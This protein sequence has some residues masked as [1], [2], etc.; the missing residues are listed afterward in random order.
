[1]NTPVYDVD[2]SQWID[3]KGVNRCLQNRQGRHPERKGSGGRGQTNVG[4]I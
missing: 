2:R 4:L 3:T 1:M